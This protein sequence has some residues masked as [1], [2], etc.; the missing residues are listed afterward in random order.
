MDAGAK[1]AKFAFGWSFPSL[2]FTKTCSGFL[3]TYTSYL[4]H[5]RKVGLY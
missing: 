1:A 5:R 2:F 3:M 4:L